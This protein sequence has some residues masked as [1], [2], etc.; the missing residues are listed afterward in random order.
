MDKELKTYTTELVN[1]GETESIIRLYWLLLKMVETESEEYYWEV[2]ELFSSLHQLKKIEG[3]DECLS[4]LINFT[5]QRE[6]NGRKKFKE[7][8]FLLFKLGYEENIFIPQASDSKGKFLN[9]VIQCVDLKKYSYL[10]YFLE[11]YA[12]T[13]KDDDKDQVLAFSKALLAYK[14][15]RYED[16]RI[17]LISQRFK[18]DVDKIRTK[19]LLT[20]SIYEE[21]II[22]DSQ[23]DLLISHLMAFRKFLIRNKKLP[24]QRIASYLNYLKFIKSMALH[25]FK[26]RVNKEFKLRLLKK[27]ENQPVAN[28]EWLI[29]QLNI[30]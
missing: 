16:A 29:E 1:N 25:H 17:A 2:K 21:Y 7:E 8:V 10:E 3:V 5:I 11:N 20:K 30:L 28:K 26:R 4:Y 19:S 15:K 22:D 14:T 13:L 23:Y 6:R 24:S 18:T 27:L 12:Y 9:M